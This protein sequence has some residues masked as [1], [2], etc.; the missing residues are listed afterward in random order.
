MLLVLAA[1][2]LALTQA[3]L[4]S[5]SSLGHFSGQFIT[6]CLVYHQVFYLKCAVQMHMGVEHHGWA[7]GEPDRGVL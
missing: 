2:V 7:M 1:A 5:A 3:F 6:C 4:R